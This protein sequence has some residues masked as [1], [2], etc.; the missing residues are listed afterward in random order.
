MKKTSLLAVSLAAVVAGFAV[1]TGCGPD[2]E[3]PQKPATKQTEQALSSTVVISQF[4]GSGANSNA[5]WNADWVELHNI[6]SSDV[7]LAD[8]H[9]QYASATG[10]TWNNHADL[11]SVTIPAGGFYLVQLTISA[12]PSTWRAPA[13]SSCSFRATGR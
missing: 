4:Y 1:G 2:Y 12:R 7:S 6:S 10:N 11:P 8:M 9:L 3:G 5:V 13:A